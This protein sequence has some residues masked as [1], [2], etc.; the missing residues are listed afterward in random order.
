MA[1]VYLLHRCGKIAIP[2]STTLC[3]IAKGSLGWEL[4][5]KTHAAQTQ[6]HLSVLWKETS[7][8]RDLPA[9]LSHSDTCSLLHPSLQHPWDTSC[10]HP[11]QVGM[12]QWGWRNR[13]LLLT[14][15]V[16]S[17]QPWSLFMSFQP[18][19]QQQQQHLL[20]EQPDFAQSQG[21]PNTLDHLFYI[22]YTPAMLLPGRIKQ[23]TSFPQ[24]TFFLQLQ[25]RG[26]SLPALGCVLV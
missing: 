14:N 8:S 24:P 13:D 11:A 5:S 1:A 26:L 15:S 7:E 2:A 17:P 18:R 22:T 19:Q 21:L 6:R 12:L 4:D 20:S 16:S 10:L 25:L 3:S 23:G 9:L